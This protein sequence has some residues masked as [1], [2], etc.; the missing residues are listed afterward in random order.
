MGKFFCPLGRF[1]PFKLCQLLTVEF[2]LLAVVLGVSLIGLMVYVFAGEKGVFILSLIISPS[3]RG[4]L[5]YI[6]LL[7]RCQIGLN[8]PGIRWMRNIS[9]WG[10]SHDKSDG[11]ASP[12]CDFH[13]DLDE[14]VFAEYRSDG[15]DEEFDK[16]EE[17]HEKYGLTGYE[18]MPK[19]KTEYFHLMSTVAPPVPDDEVDMDGFLG[20]EIDPADKDCELL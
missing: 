7:L 15:S 18:E 8:H 10:K 4:F 20:V 6:W 1:G 2:A 17:S 13:C 9:V 14:A 12:D 16:V 3:S 5:Y 19:T 11:E